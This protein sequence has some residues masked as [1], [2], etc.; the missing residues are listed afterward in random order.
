MRNLGEREN[1]KRI[2]PKVQFYC[3]IF[4]LYVQENRIKNAIKH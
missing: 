1:K 2:L 4:V 3:M